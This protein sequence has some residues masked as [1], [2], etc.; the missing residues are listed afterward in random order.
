MKL[1]LVT[2]K[3]DRSDPILGFFHGWIAEFAQQCGYVCVL[4][5]YVGEY[6]FAGKVTVESL[7]KERG[8]PRLVQV[9]RFLSLQWRL[10]KQ[11]D[12]ALVHM[13][14]IWVVLGA[15]LWFLLR[16]RIYLWYEARG[17]RWPLRIALLSVRKVFSASQHGMPL[18]TRKSIVVGHGIDTVFFAPGDGGR[19]EKLLL[20]VGRI[21]ASKNL[22]VIIRT[23]AQ[24]P[25]EYRLVIVGKS[26][27]KADAEL[28]FRLREEIVRRGIQDRV[29]IQSASQDVLQPLLRRASVFVHASMT[30]LDKAVLEAM[31]SGCIVVSTSEAVRPLLQPVCQATA[32]TLVARI[33]EVCA[34][35]ERERGEIAAEQRQRVVQEHGLTRLVRR[36][37]AEMAA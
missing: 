3:V 17:A 29:T 20:T 31:A 34:L 22:D 11:Y 9:L 26:I 2:Q 14:P 16:K 23:F 33:Q 12:V 19:E 15:P 4:G 28:S 18:R 25:E 10:R 36:L 5:Q 6:S 27:T 32:E 35:S 21:T 1:L 37:V 7:G 13:T 8:A 30:S 24:L